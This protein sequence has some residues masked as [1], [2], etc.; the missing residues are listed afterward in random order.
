MH[1]LSEGGKIVTQVGPESKANSALAS[2]DFPI[3]VVVVLML[4]A[5]GLSIDSWTGFTVMILIAFAIAAGFLISYRGLERIR[6]DSRW[7]D[8]MTNFL[9]RRGAENVVPGL[10]GKAPDGTLSQTTTYTVEGQEMVAV[11]TGAPDGSWTTI[12]VGLA[13]RDGAS[14]AGQKEDL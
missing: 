6:L 7:S 13:D 2:L 5:I 8:A 11:L 10:V 1:T 9:V 4:Q 14:D 3:V 12:K